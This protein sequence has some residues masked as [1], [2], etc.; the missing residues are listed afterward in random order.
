MVAAV[1]MKT[2]ANRNMAR[3]AGS[4]A[5]ETS[6]NFA[7]PRMPQAFPPIRIATSW[8]SPTDAPRE[9]HC[10]TPPYMSP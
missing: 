7:A 10:A 6:A 3:F 4:R 2:V 1:S 5:T 9:G 8:A